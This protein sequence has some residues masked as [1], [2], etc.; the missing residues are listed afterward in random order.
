MAVPAFQAPQTAHLTAEAG[1]PWSRYAPG[2]D[3]IR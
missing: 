2:Y 3:H 1:S